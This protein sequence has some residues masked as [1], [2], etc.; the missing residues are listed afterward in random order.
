MIKKDKKFCQMVHLKLIL[1][2]N[3][4][5][6]TCRESNNGTL[7]SFGY[8]EDQAAPEAF[9]RKSQRMTRIRQS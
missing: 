5:P 9:M 6:G 3:L 7:K 2:W 8:L 4:S 1:V